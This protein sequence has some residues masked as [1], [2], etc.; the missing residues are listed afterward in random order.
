MQLLGT[1]EPLSAVRVVTGAIEVGGDTVDAAGN[2]VLMVTIPQHGANAFTV[3]AQDRA[4]NRSA[5]EQAFTL[6][7]NNPSTLELMWPGAT[8]NIGAQSTIRWRTKDADS[9]TVGDFRIEIRKAIAGRTVAQSAWQRVADGLKTMSY[10][11]T[12][13]AK[14]SSGV[15][16]MRISGFDGYERSEVIA[17]VRVDTVPPAL[18][19]RSLIPERTN[20]PSVKGEGVAYDDFSGVGVVEFSLGEEAFTKATLVSGYRTPTS[21]YRFVFPSALD[22]GTYVL[23]LR[24][25]DE[26]ENISEVTSV[27]FTID[28]TPPRIGSWRMMLGPLQLFPNME[29]VLEVFAGTS[30]E[31][32][33]AVS[34]DAQRT[35]FFVGDTPFNLHEASGQIFKSSITLEKPGTHMMRVEVADDLGNKKSVE[36]GSIRV[37][38]PAQIVRA[39]TQ[40]P[41]AGAK[42]SAYFYDKDSNAW[43]LWDGEAYGQ[44]NPVESDA[45][46][47]FRYFLPEGTYELRVRASEYKRAKTSPFTLQKPTL[48][49]L[50]IPL[51]KSGFWERVLQMFGE[52]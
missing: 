5:T 9:D 45:A 39:R 20:N 42:V 36:V 26:A 41:V 18:F 46:G 14:L 11:W 6:I 28:T 40:E 23:K 8:D 30:Y 52:K 38:S 50:T 35:V 17:Q 10:T 25:T 43:L 13:A 49:T 1:S 32:S 15:Y 29:G 48:V 27:R 16:E 24:A 44:E 37:I 12:D 7:A 19:P 2:I 21:T 34:Q 31:Y 33:L 3:Y 22:D 47:T 4:G 51:E